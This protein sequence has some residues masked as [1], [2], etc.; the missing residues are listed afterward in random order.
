MTTAI[1]DDLPAWAEPFYG[2]GPGAAPGPALDGPVTPVWAY[3]DGTGRGVRVAIVDSGIDATH[4]LVRGVAQSVAITVDPSTAEGV[5]VDEGPHDDLYGHGTACAALVR[6]LAPEVELVSVRVLG[7]N[8]KGSALAFAYGL[9]WCLENGVQVANLSLSTTNDSYSGT[10]H[11][12]PDR[13]AFEGLLLVGIVASLVLLVI[14]FRRGDAPRAGFAALVLTAVIVNAAAGGAL[15]RP[16][17][18]YEARIAWLVLLP[19]LM[20]PGLPSSLRHR[21]ERSE[22][23]GSPG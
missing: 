9:E 15:S 2:A 23:R 16:N 10:F 3:G 6:S 17:P 8:L 1:P 12:L 7:A 18:R 13:A 11:D 4:P 22:H 19:G 21:P 5:R 20:V 14:A